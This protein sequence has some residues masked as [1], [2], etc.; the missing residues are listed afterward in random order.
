MTCKTCGKVIDQ[1]LF[2]DQEW[3]W[4]LGQTLYFCTY[5]CM[6]EYEKTQ[7]MTKKFLVTNGKERRKSE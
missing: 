5:R 2:E 3:G 1:I 4:K 7:K 6:R